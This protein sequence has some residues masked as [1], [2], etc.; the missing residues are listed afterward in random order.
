MKLL[1]SAK[2]RDL[3]LNNKMLMS[4]MTRSRA[5]QNGMVG[6]PFNDLRSKCL[7]EAF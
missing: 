6:D 7:L 5:D 1:E 2:L 4:A 3:T